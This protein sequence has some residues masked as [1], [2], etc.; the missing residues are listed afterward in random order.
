MKSTIPFPQE[1]LNFFSKQLLLDDREREAVDRHNS[2]FIARKEAFAQFFYDYFGNIDE[3][4]AILEHATSAETMKNVW[5]HWFGSLFNERQ[6]ET[7]LHYMWRSGLRHV[8]LHLDQRF[9]S[10]AYSIARQ[11]C[12]QIARAEVPHADVGLVLTAWTKSLISA[13]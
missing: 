9:V 3:T 6:E 12:H 10:L 8:E 2:L 1:N 5:G 7:F 11:Y 4:K 13:S